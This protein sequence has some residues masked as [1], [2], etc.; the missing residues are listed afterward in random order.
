MV[1]IKY[2]AKHVPNSCK[3]Q[4]SCSYGHSCH[5]AASDGHGKN[6]PLGHVISTSINYRLRPSSTSVILHYVL[7]LCSFTQNNTCTLTRQSKRYVS[8]PLGGFASHKESL[9]DLHYCYLLYATG[10][11]IQDIL[12]EIAKKGTELSL[13]LRKSMWANGTHE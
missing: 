8:V 7:F 1:T 9:N 11:S 2:M 12:I 13:R 6:T 5:F 10:R 4:R 3:L